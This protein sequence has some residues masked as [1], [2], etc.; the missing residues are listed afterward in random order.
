MV[1]TQQWYH[2]QRRR[3]Q[4]QQQQNETNERKRIECNIANRTALCVILVHK[5][6]SAHHT[7]Y[8]T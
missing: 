8:R 5:H 6:A 1:V 7:S 4:Q 3:Q 2:Q